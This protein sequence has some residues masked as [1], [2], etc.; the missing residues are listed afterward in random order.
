MSM[1]Q[2][3]PWTAADE[4]KDTSWTE[5]GSE[6]A[7]PST[8]S[9]A[10][11]GVEPPPPQAESDA[12]ANRAAKSAMVVADARKRRRARAGRDVA[13][14]RCARCVLWA[15]KRVNGGLSDERVARRVRGE[16]DHYRRR[17]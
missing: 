12:I 11:R 16:C 9:S 3:G 14:A 2:L 6:N 4:L 7:A 8:T 17:A 1:A 5:P 15:G 13:C 10:P